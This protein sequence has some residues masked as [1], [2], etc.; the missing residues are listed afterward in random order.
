MEIDLTGLVLPEHVEVT[1]LS[2]DGK[3]AE[4]V[5]QPLER[6]YGYTLGNSVRRALVASL[7]GAAIWAFRIE[8]VVHEH[9][10][11]QGVVEDVHQVIQNLKAL[12][13]TLDEDVDEAKLTVHVG[14][15]RTGDGRRHQRTGI[16][17]G[18]RSDPAHPHAGGRPQPEHGALRQQGAWFRALRPAPPAGGRRPSTWCRSM[19]STIPVRRANFRVEET[20][21]G[22]RTDFDRLS[23]RVETDGSI[24]P[25][26]AMANAAALVRRYLE[27]LLG[28]SANGVAKPPAAGFLPLP[29]RVRAQLARPIEDVTEI[30]VRLRNSLQKEN[31]RTLGDLVRRSEEQVLS[32]DNFGQKSLEELLAFL[33][34]HSIELGMPLTMG[35]DGEWCLAEEE[36]VPDPEEPSVD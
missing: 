16:G 17:R 21:V 14:R 5:I 29:A 15:R 32:I 30:S 22:E 8:G 31:L 28:F 11:I 36:T 13:L 23:F 3:T 33:G 20:R 19:R 12:V 26:R 35:P 6:G 25:E 9:Q 18:A 1:S 34:E 2:D 10:T 7:R 24:R 27:Y 4:F